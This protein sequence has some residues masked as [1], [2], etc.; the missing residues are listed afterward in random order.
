MR[1]ITAAR[2]PVPAVL[3]NQSYVDLARLPAARWGATVRRDF[4]SLPYAPIT[5]RCSFFY[6]IISFIGGS[7]TTKSNYVIL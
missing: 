3:A 6:R 4:V 2:L 1:R 7:Y 5:A